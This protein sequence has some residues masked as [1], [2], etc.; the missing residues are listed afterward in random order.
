MTL[1]R[2]CQVHLLPIPHQWSVVYRS[3]NVPPPL[4]LFLLS[5]HL[6]YITP[7]PTLS[8]RRVQLKLPVT[9]RSS[10]H[11]HVPFHIH[12]IYYDCTSTT[13]VKIPYIYPYPK[14]VYDSSLFGDIPP[15]CTQVGT[16]Y[17]TYLY[18]DKYKLPLITRE[19][20]NLH[21]RQAED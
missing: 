3:N 20:L 11:I 18:H 5:A 7:R 4:R 6:R 1:K 21:E 9:L 12:I 8:R 17:Y 16:K 13:H 15:L 19:T 10:F 14:H 2:S